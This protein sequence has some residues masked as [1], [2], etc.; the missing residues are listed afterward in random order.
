MP[1]RFTIDTERIE[2]NRRRNTWH[3]I[4][5]IAAMVALVAAVGWFFA[6]PYGLV[7]IVLLATVMFAIGP[8]LSQRV[9]LQIYAASPLSRRQV[10]LLYDLTDELRDRLDL[11]RDVRLFYI[12]SRL[13]LAFTVGGR[14]EVSVAV[15]DG[16]LRGLT[17]RELSGVLAHELSHVAHGDLQLMALADF[18]T[19]ATRT[20][21]LVAM[22]LIA[23]NLP[24][25]ME[26]NVAIPWPPI[27]LLAVAPMVSLLLQ[28]GL[29]RAREYDAD[30]SAAYLTGDPEGIA[31]ALQKMEAQQ[32]RHWETLLG[33]SGTIKEPSLLRTHPDTEERVRRLGELAV[34]RDEELPEIP[35][36]LEPPGDG[37]VRRKPSRRMHGFRY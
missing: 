3:A 11:R 37:P 16:L 35:D 7:W 5:L 12:P 22:L 18:V 2:A 13:M 20:M 6:G 28:L 31:S 29:S 9:M 25:I 26:E 19:K 8:R 30:V 24:Y 4:V 32:R 10:P 34:P 23:I 27:A 14:E 21:A 36:D 17:G 33:R 15:S 1:P